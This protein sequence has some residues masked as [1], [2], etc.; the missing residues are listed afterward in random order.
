MLRIATG[1]ELRRPR[2]AAGQQ[3][4]LVQQAL[5][6]PGHG[7]A[8][9]DDGDRRRHHLAQQRLEKGVMGAA[10]ND[11]VATRRQQWRDVTLQ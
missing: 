7:G 4:A 5:Q 11:R 2:G 3:V 1:P 6:L 10:E 9:I 8:G